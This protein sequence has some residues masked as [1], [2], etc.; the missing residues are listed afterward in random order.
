MLIIMLSVGAVLLSIAGYL[1][2][3][4]LQAWFEVKDAPRVP[5]H[6]CPKHGA[7][8]AKYTLKLDILAERPID[9]CPMCWEDKVKA[10]KR[11]T[12]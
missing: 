12:L 10:A 6:L 4:M 5:M 2:L 7:I 11:G 3:V 9:Y 8:P 1:L